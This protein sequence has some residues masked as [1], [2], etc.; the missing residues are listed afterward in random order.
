MKILT[1]LA[2]GT[3]ALAMLA[4]NS[5]AYDANYCYHHPKQEQCQQQHHHHH[6]YHSWHQDYDHNNDHSGNKHYENQGNY[7]N[8]QP[9]PG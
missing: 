7:N 3:V 4:G 2:L 8:G 9:H 1:T 5:S 6:W